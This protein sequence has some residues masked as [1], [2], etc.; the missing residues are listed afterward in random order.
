MNILCHIFYELYILVVENLPYGR[1]HLLVFKT[2][3]MCEVEKNY[4]MKSFDSVI[5]HSIIIL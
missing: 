5:F 2:E 1:S 4:S 3:C